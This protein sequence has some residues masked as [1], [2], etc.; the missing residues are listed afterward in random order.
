M[1]NAPRVSLRQIS[2]LLIA[3]FFGSFLA[4]PALAQRDRGAAKPNAS[5]GPVPRMADGTP[6]LTG[7]WWTGGDINP[8]APS[9]AER[10]TLPQYNQER[11]SALAKLYQPWA[12]QKMKELGDKDDP[13]LHCIPAAIGM[14][15]Q[16][17]VAQ[18]VQTPQFVI[19]LI[20]TYHG[21]RV[22]P[23]NG[24]HNPD[25][26]PSYRGDAV[27]RWDGDTFVTDVRNF[28]D[29]NWL[30]AEGNISFHSDALRVTERYRRL[31]A[32]TLEYQAT[33]E[34][35]KVLTA[36]WQMPKRTFQIAPFDRV[37]AAD[38]VDQPGARLMEGAAK[39]N[40]GRPPSP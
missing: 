36:P 6:D 4:A 20:E 10:L 25:A 13:A 9:L 1:Y 23:I 12:L 37:M 34:D 28:T 40:Y 18:L 14:V 16:G 26:L 21:F 33:V 39:V 32:E 35:P 38:C 7:V 17:A 19:N 27:G 2:A 24:T 3:V 5:A 11:P 29:A 15:G 31:D 8:N 22:I 30:Q